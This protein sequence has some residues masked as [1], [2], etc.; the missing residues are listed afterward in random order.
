[1][2]VCCR[3]IRSTP[4]SENNIFKLM[5]RERPVGSGR[6][7]LELCLWHLPSLSLSMRVCKGRDETFHVLDAGI[8]LVRAL[9]EDLT[10][11]EVLTSGEVVGMA[12]RCHGTFVSSPFSKHR[13]A[14]RRYGISCFEIPQGVLA[15]EPVS[16]GRRS[17]GGVGPV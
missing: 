6:R 4:V 14:S 3:G 7:A 12:S 13:G 11:K 5:L 10:A 15:V 1:M 8:S 2:L 9:C 17:H 16:L